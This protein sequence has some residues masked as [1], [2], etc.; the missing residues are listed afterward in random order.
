MKSKRI[1]PGGKKM[2]KLQVAT[3]KFRERIETTA[4]VV[5]RCF[6]RCRRP[7]SG[8]P[9][10][11]TCDPQCGTTTTSDS[12][13]QQSASRAAVLNVAVP[14]LAVLA[15][16]SVF[17][18]PALLS[19]QNSPE[20]GPPENNAPTNPSPNNPRA[21]S[22]RRGVPPN[23]V[24]PQDAPQ[25]PQPQQQPAPAPEPQAATPAPEEAAPAAAEPAAVPNS[26]LQQPAS[27]AQVKISNGMLSVQADNSN[28]SQVL[29][30]I[31]SATGMKVEGLGRDERVFGH[32]GPATPRDVLTA[33]LDGAGYNVLMVG[34]ISSGTPKQLIL[35]QRKGGASAPAPPPDPNAQPPADE[36]DVEPDAPLTRKAHHPRPRRSLPLHP[37]LRKT[38]SAHPSSYWSSCSACTRTSLQTRYSRPSHRRSSNRR[39]RPLAA[40]TT[41]F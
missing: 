16:V 38:T 41:I 18:I 20:S 25:Q 10:R 3:I 35:S 21:W 27:R 26:M 33:L 39:R 9:W 11:L 29:H 15:L 32:Y 37:L 4:N 5:Q 31:G 22:Q 40:Y 8:Q 17:F 34:D 24:R 12:P 28:L 30:D 6:L 19:A 36:E 14:M 23:L 7:V 1:V 2:Q 13:T